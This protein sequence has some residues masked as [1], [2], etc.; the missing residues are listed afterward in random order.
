MPFAAA[1]DEGPLALPERGF[2]RSQPHGDIAATGWPLA[3]EDVPRNSVLSLFFCA[4]GRAHPLGGCMPLSPIAALLRQL[5]ERERPP[6]RSQVQIVPIAFA[7]A[8][9]DLGSPGCDS[10]HRGS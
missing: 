6:T 5:R 9:S 4:P 8:L 10:A 2:K 3:S 1:A 7:S